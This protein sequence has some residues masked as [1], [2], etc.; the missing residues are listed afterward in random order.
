MSF[1]D[2]PLIDPANMPIWT[3]SAFILAVVALMVAFMAVQRT[4]TLTVGTQLE[5]LALTKR[6]NAEHPK[7]APAAVAPV[8]ALPAAPT[9][10]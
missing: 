1:N 4:N 7:A 10:K 5:V 8:P 6:L 3:A 2:K 9:A